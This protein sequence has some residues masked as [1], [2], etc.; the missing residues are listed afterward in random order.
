VF[1]V[2]C[3]SA[4]NDAAHNAAPPANVMAAAE[5]EIGPDQLTTGYSRAN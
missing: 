3:G 5:D 1:Q 2:N 4:R